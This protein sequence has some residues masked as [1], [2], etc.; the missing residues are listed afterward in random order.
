MLFAA[1]AESTK[2]QMLQESQ[3]DNMR[4]NT[5]HTKMSMS[6]DFSKFCTTDFQR[7]WRQLQFLYCHL[8][9]E[10]AS[11]ATISHTV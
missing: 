2:L 1:Q 4:N 7:E 5:K 9:E 8:T 3:A 11:D 10:K 6:H